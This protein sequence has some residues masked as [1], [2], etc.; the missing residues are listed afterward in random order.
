M[1]PA[2]LPAMLDLWVAAWQVTMP[3]IDFAARRDWFAERL[4]GFSR[5]GVAILCAVDAAAVVGLV[6]IDSRTR[7]L[8]QL[9]VTPTAFGQGI[10]GKLLEAAKRVSPRAI[11]LLVNQDN[12]RAIRFYE[13]EGFT[14]GEPATGTTTGRPVWRMRWAGG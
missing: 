6:T 2:D 14:L 11:E 7:Y 3:D 5:A 9:A 12:P 13:R 4:E 1:R 10:A 8:D